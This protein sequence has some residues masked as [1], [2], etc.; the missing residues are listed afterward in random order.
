VELAGEAKSQLYITFDKQGTPTDLGILWE[1][2]L[3]LVADASEVKYSGGVEEG[4]TA[5]S[6]QAYK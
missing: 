3:K 1:S 2:E 5:A 6:A 4:L